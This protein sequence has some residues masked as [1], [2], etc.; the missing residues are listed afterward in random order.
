M[1]LAVWWLVQ[2]L[3]FKDF[4][5]GGGSPRHEKGKASADK[6]LTLLTI[7]AILRA[8]LRSAAGTD[9]WSAELLLLLWWLGRDWLMCWM[10]L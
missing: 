5:I 7:L 9:V 10:P 1:I 6:G 3:E 8:Q 4:M 2:L